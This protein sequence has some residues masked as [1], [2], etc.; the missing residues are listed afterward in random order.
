M[1]RNPQKA[2]DLERIAKQLG[3]EKEN[4]GKEPV[5]VNPSLG[6]LPLSIPHHGGQDLPIGTRNSIL[7]VLETDLLAWEER[8]GE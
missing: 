2:R 5:W 4:R 6:V 7:N 1:R 3:R 8:L